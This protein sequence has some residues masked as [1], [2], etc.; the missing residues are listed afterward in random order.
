M[1]RDRLFAPPYESWEIEVCFD[2]WGLD[3]NDLTDRRTRDGRSGRAATTRSSGVLDSIPGD[4]R[5]V[6]IEIVTAWR[7]ILAPER[8]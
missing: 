3:P 7:K 6:H 5:E 1:L 2:R 4:D 8:V